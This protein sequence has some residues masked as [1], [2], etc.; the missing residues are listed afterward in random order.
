[1][2]PAALALALGARG[3]FLG[4]A[5]CHLLSRIWPPLAVN[6]ALAIVVSADHILRACTACTA[7]GAPDSLLPNIAANVIDSLTPIIRFLLFAASI[8][9][10]LRLGRA[11]ERWWAARQAFS[12]VGSAATALCQRF[13]LWAPDGGDGGGSGEEG[14]AAAMTRWAIAWHYSILHVCRGARALHKD[15]ARLLAPEELAVYAA[16]RK[17]RQICVEALL[18]I[19]SDADLEAKKFDALEAILQ[20]GVAAAGV[21]TGVRFQALPYGLTLMSSGF[22]E[23]FLVALVLAMVQEAS[24]AGKAAGDTFAD[25]AFTVASVLAL[26]LGVNLL[27]L[28]ADEV[29]NQ[30]EDP[31]PWLPLEDIAATTARN[32]ARAPGELRAL[33]AAARARHA[34]GAAGAAAALVGGSA[35]AMRALAL[36]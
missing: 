8:I 20:R 30:L 22:V 23:F 33:R 29:A 13:K 35:S 3:L 4:G 2:A 1:M 14:P 15:A 34:K 5:P 32:A 18:Q 24:A 7:A 21:C 25:T 16:A 6:L 26:Y 10:T 19:T 9:L 11:Y 28:G 36:A 17:G 12:A 31:F 27:F